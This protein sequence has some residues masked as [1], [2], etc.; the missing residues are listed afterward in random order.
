MNTTTTIE[1]RVNARIGELVRDGKTIYYAVL[2]GGLTVENASRD[3]IAA[4]VRA[5]ERVAAMPAK[6]QHYFYKV[7]RKDTNE[8]IGETFK[9]RNAVISAVAEIRKS[10]PGVEISYTT[11]I[12]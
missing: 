3:E 12:S 2:K 11:C 9:S 10:L 6:S 7:F 1:S 8:Q 4:Y 5:E